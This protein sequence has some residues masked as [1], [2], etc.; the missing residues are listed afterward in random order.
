MTCV[1]SVCLKALVLESIV[2]WAGVIDELDFAKRLHE[3]SNCGFRELGDRDGFVVSNTITKVVNDP[4]YLTEPHSTGQRLMTRIVEEEPDA[5]LDNGAL[6]R[7]LILGKSVHF[8]A[9][10]AIFKFK[11]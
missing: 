3:W 4:E 11:N 5:F 10:N 1:L 2:N 9:S 7:C 6:A 8:I